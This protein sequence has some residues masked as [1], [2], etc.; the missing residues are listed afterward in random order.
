VLGI[1]FV[2]GGAV[3]GVAFDPGRSGEIGHR[4]DPFDT[5]IARRRAAGAASEEEVVDGIAKRA[6]GGAVNGPGGSSRVAE[7]AL[8]LKL[9]PNRLLYNG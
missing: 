6:G 9:Q 1:F 5:G 3:G 4:V 7:C 2:N 8:L